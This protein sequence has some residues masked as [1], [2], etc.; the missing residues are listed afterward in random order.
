MATYGR[1]QSFAVDNAGNGLNAASIEVRNELT[2]NLAALFST[3]TGSSLGNPFNSD[4]DGFFGFHVAGGAYKITV[5]KDALTR[6]FRYVP[7]GTAGEHDASAS[8]VTYASDFGVVGDNGLSDETA[9]L[10]AAI[11]GTPS[12]G[13][14]ILPA[15]LCMVL[16]SGTTALLVT[17]PISIIGNGWSSGIFP[18]IAGGFPNTRNILSV[19][20]TSPS[21]GFVFRDFQIAAF[22]AG[23]HAMLFDSGNTSVVYNIYIQRML[24][25]ATDAGCSIFG[26]ESVN[27]PS[28]GG[29]FAYSSIQDCNLDSAQF[30]TCGDG[31]TIA[32]NVL[33]GAERTCI[34]ADQVV[35]AGN[36]VIRDNTMAS[37]FG[38]CTVRQSSSL[39]YADNEMEIQGA[40]SQT[41]GA[42]VDLA[43]DVGQILN[44]N[45]KGNIF[46]TSTGS[47]IT[48][49][50][51]LN[52]CV[53]AKISHNTFLAKGEEHI[54]IN[55][56]CL[57]VER[58]AN[59]FIQTNGLQGPK[60]TDNGVRSAI[61]P[62]T[63]ILMLSSN[64]AGSDSSTAQTWFPGGGPTG[65][66]VLDDST[67]EFEGFVA[68]A[69]TAGTNSHF[70][71]ILFQGTATVGAIQGWYE[72]SA[73]T[74]GAFAGNASAD[75][76]N[77]GLSSIVLF[78][79]TTSATYNWMVKMRG[80]IRV[81]AAGTFV[82]QIKFSAAPGGAP[83]FQA[84]CMFKMKLI[85]PDTVTSI[86]FS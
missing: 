79:T 53:G 81:T 86:G 68:Y 71:E 36:L 31:L 17:K 45:I 78:G 77:N 12:G 41:N 29:T 39:I 70:T 64:Q 16:G 19:I 32:R 59:T 23:K 4:A 75:A 52:N 1:Y 26:A 54:T 38:F 2:G 65:L 21:N 25:T 61:I 47:G 8:G 9:A 13:T 72:G 67:Y 22:G 73:G 63:H 66:S 49:Q 3:R 69:R 60:I 42:L 43:G 14:L 28:S 15:G 18:S 33:T 55:S 6:T 58:F 84:N 82:P 56:N 7:I 62:G 83:T 37:N 27:S 40:L 30:N 57:D 5:T 50:L 46:S 48:R 80:I 51:R 10:Q 44:A 74:S 35:G 76:L 85:G 11:D 34:I 20:P 24:I